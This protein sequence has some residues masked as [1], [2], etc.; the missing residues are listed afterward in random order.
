MNKEKQMEKFDENQVTFKKIL[1]N[2]GVY[3]EG[4]EL[5]IL[6]HMEEILK[7]A[8]SSKL[9]EHNREL[10]RK[11][12]ALKPRNNKKPYDGNDLNSACDHYHIGADDWYEI[13]RLEEGIERGLEKA[14]SLLALDEETK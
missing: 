5:E 7:K 3:N 8:T 2:W 1:T 14:Q 10:Y 9:L 12:E 11:L 13:L 4:L 6:R